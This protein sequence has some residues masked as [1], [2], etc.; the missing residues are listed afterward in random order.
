MS[1]EELTGRQKQLWDLLQDIKTR[2]ATADLKFIF[3]YAHVSV[4]EPHAPTRY[5]KA[6]EACRRDLQLRILQVKH[7]EEEFNKFFEE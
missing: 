5:K 3:D 6:F 7:A 4:N 1:E 2:L